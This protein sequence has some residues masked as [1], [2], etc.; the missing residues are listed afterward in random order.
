[1]CLDSYSETIYLLGGW[2]GYQDLADLWTYHI[3][4]NKWTLISEDAKVQVLYEFSPI[5]KQIY[6]SSE[7]KELILHN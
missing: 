5:F 7:Q 3:P 6:L 4:T 1:M 2:D